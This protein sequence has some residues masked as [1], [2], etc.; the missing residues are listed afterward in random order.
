MSV[1]SEPAL[2]EALP[3]TES[4]SEARAELEKAGVK[5]IF[6][7]WIDL[8]GLP[9]TKPIPLGEWEALC[10]GEGPQFAVH[11]VSMVPE[12]GP[13]DPDQIMIPD[14]DSLLVCPW[15]PRYAWVFADLFYEGRPYVVCE[16]AYSQFELDFGYTDMVGG[17]DRLTFLRVLL[18]EV[19][20]RHGLFVTYMAKPTQGDWRSGAHI[21]H[22]IQALDRPGVNLFAAED[23]G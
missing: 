18:K 6:C 3:S 13:A 10:R 16:G 5:Y 17:A 9:K 11:S 19:A 4:V 14:L 2:T 23:G 7:C 8:L 1:I 22:S 12:L 20:K 21:N 15:E